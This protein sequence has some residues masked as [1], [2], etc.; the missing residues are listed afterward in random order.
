MRQIEMYGHVKQWLTQENFTCAIVAPRMSLVVPLRDLVPAPYRIPDLVGFRDGKVVI[1]E[2]ERRKE[3]LFE[4]L[5]KCMVW[6]C[7]ASFVYL[8]YPSGVFDEIPVLRRLGLGLLSVDS[9]GGSVTATLPLPRSGIDLHSVHELHPLDF[10]RE[11]GLLRQL[12][13]VCSD[14]DS[15]AQ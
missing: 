3:R 6:K 9:E 2:V 10:Q 12:Q 1:I 11:Q 14:I 8:A 5:G 13:S 4:A 15:Q 7:I